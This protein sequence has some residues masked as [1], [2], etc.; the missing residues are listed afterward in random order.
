MVAR[1]AELAA[2]E[3]RLDPRE[4]R[5]AIGVHAQGDLGLAA[6]AAEVAFADKNF[7]KEPDFELDQL[8]QGRVSRET[9]LLFH[10]QGFP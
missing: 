2:G 5:V 3:A 4:E 9:C 6:I 1:S 7:E 8:F 10:R